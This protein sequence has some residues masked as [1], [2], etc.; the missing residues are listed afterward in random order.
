MALHLEYILFL[1][2]RVA[3]EMIQ[4]LIIKYATMQWTMIQ[5]MVIQ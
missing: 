5:N 1:T 2:Y 3:H 4:Y